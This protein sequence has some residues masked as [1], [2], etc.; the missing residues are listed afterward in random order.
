MLRQLSIPRDPSRTPLVSVTF[1]IDRIGAPFDF[2]DLTIAS[3]TAPKAY[4]NFELQVN[5]VDSG[6]DLVVE[7]DYNADLFDGPTLRRWLSHYETLLRGVVA[8]PDDIVERLPLLTTDECTAL[9]SATAASTF[10]ADRC[11]HERFE[12]Q[13]QIAPERV[14]A[15]CEGASLTYGELDRRANALAHEL[16]SLGVSPGVLVG[17][18]AERSLDLVVGILGILKAGGAYLP[19][20]PAYPKERVEFMLADSHVRVVVTETDFASDFEGGGRELVLLDRERAEEAQGPAAGATPSDLAYVIYTSGSTG[21]P[22][23]VLITHYNV[24]RLFDATEDWFHFTEDDVWTLFHSY[25]FDFSVWELWGALLYGG[26]L[27]VVPYWVSRSPE[28][29]RELLER[30]GVSVLNQTPSAFRQLIQ[31]DAHSGPPALSELRY[32][33]FGGEALE[34][35]SLRPWFE[36]YGDE[37]PK[38]VNMYGITETTVHVTYRPISL[39]DLEA[40]AGSVIGVP[41]PDLKVQLLDQQGALVPIGVPGELYVGGAGVSR[42]YLE[43]PELTAERFVPDPAAA[44]GSSRLYRTGDLGRRL[45]SGDLEYLGRIDDQVKLRGF[46]IELGEIEAVLGEHPAVSE[47]VVFI[48]E[49]V[50]SD[51]RLVAYV[52]SEDAG[53]IEELKTHVRTQLPEYMVPAHFLLL[54]TLP[55]TPNGKVDRKALPAPD[56]GASTAGT[57]HVAPR[58][59]TESQ[60]AAIWAEALGIASPGVH[61][62]FFDLGGHSLMAAQIVTAIRSAFHVDAAVRHLLAKPTIAGLAEIV[63]LLAGSAAVAERASGSAREEIGI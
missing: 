45:E 26:R 42:G 30:E 34:L 16:R 56:P 11:L 55:L 3:I 2:G 60:I 46:R 6:S 8:R 51:K 7:C 38:L 57:P 37:R 48:R 18:R 36:R 27:V 10:P 54:P 12:K 49:D 17:L 9:E 28:D 44:D 23:G 20:D 1:S 33:I 52:V 61:D 29:F 47:C 13:A 58:T 35:Q 41:I 15:S 25:A 21:K 5:V 4:S 32:V 62:D 39:Y 31:A 43:R 22:K 53:V 14:A 50:A 40:D 19:L 59:P 63:D 24:T